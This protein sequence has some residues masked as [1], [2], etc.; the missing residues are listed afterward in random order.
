MQV[1]ILE[2]EQEDNMIKC[3]CKKLGEEAGD[4][5]L[6]AFIKSSVSVNTDVGCRM[7]ICSPWKLMQL[8]NTS[9]P[10]VFVYQARN[11]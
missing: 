3:R 9:A 4:R 1:E 7:T 8:R 10:L 5:F 6:F 11:M 2:K